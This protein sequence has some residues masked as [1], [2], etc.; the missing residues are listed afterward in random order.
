MSRIFARLLGASLLFSLLLI[1]RPVSAHEEVESGS[2]IFEIGWVNEPVIAGQLNGLDLF[3]YPKDE[4]SESES[5]GGEHEHAEGV[6]D[7]E[8][9]LAFTVDYG[10]V[11]QSYDLLPVLD[12]P[13][14]Y[15]ATFLPTR[16]GQYTFHFTGTINGE[17]VDL[18]FDPEE[19]EAPGKLAFP[20]APPSTADLLAQLSAVQAQARTAQTVGIVGVVLGLIGTGIGVVSLTRKK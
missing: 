3:I 2:Y 10:G 8:G 9:T 15:T 11:S 20:E 6:A 4:H 12:T 16:E 7:A 13:G 14:A 19:V 5:E 18:S 17:V 1:S